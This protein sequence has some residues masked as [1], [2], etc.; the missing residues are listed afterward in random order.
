M[1]F[2]YFF[3]KTDEMLDDYMGK[4]AIKGFY[5]G[6]I[7]VAI[8]TLV[9]LFSKTPYEALTIGLALAGLS[10]LEFMHY[11]QCTMDIKNDGH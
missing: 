11:L 5:G 2:E 10:A 3:R 4:S 9:N 7:A 6:M 1:N 8:I